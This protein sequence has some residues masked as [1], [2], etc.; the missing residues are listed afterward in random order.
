[1]A[2][3]I[4]L[5]DRSRR[6]KD[7][8]PVPMTPPE[9]IPLNQQAIPQRAARARAQARLLWLAA[10][11]PALA[12]LM[13]VIAPPLNHD[14]AAVLNFAERWLAGER[15]YTDLI[16]VNPPLVFVLTLVPAAIG[17]W[18]P[19][20]GVQALL[21]CV[22]AVCALATWLALR[23]VRG[24]PPVELAALGVVVPLLTLVAGYDFG[25]REH[26]MAVAAIPYLFLAARRM[27]GLS[28]GRGL[29]LGCA[30]LAALGFALKPHFLVVPALVE[31]LVLLRL[32][33]RRALRDAVPW[34]MAAVWLGYLAAIP[35][36]FPDYFGHVLP[37]VWDYYLDL[38]GF[39]WWQVILTERLGTALMLLVPLAVVAA[40]GAWGALPKVLAVAALGATV[41]AVVQHKGWTYHVLPVRMLA[42]LLAVVLAARW[43]DRTLPTT[44]AARLAPAAA[45]VAAFAIGIHNFAGAEAPWRQVTWSWSHA[46]QL[47]ALLKR[48][49][50]G[51]RLLVL[52]PDIFP[53]YPAL[54]YARAQS[55]LRTMN[56]WLLQGVYG[57]CPEDGARY[58]ETWDMSRTE[59]FIYRTVAEDFA[60]APPAAILI[61]TD[62]RIPRCGKE[63]D[64]LEYFSRHPLFAETLRRYR[65]AA[66]LHGYR[67]LRRED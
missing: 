48:E 21:A 66:E 47:S 42:G 32:G 45:V 37:L 49:A 4:R 23:L 19:L 34:T 58:R 11:V 15:L 36:V 2:A 29:T 44:R 7:A 14:V 24:R 25:Q 52:S 35:V 20:D 38:G 65:P 63:F 61:A 17:A 26:L 60:R 55:T 10:L 67:L 33:P 46:G 51:E 5:Q 13:T 53:V 50:Y 9:H 57:R 3:A 28:A 22:L 6:A 64:V 18:T 41:A 31:A 40:R 1:M 54:N 62:P 27:E 59:F 16:D 39:A 12:F 43:L 56:I 8:P 30:V